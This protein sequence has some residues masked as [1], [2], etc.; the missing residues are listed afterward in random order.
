MERGAS[1]LSARGLTP[2]FLSWEGTLRIDP[3]SQ[4]GRTLV[5]MRIAAALHTA[6][7]AIPIV[8]ITS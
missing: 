1:L 4:A 6:A 8:S 2:L 3:T 7:K 5:A